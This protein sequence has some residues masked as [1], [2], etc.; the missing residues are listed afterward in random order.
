MVKRFRRS[1]A[2]DDEQLPSDISPPLVLQRTLNYLLEEIVAGPETLSKVHKFVWDRTRAIRND[3]SIQQVTEPDDVRVAMDCFERI[4][5]FHIL[6]LHQLSL[7][8]NVENSDFDAHQELEQLSKTLLSLTYYY[9]DNRGTVTSP[10][11]AEFRAYSIMIEIG[12]PR[13][14]LEQRANI[15]DKHVLE[16]QQVQM[17]LSLYAMCGGIGDGEGPWFRGTS[18]EVGRGNPRSF[19]PFLKSPKVPYLLAC[20]AEISFY[21]IRGLILESVWN[22]FKDGNANSRQMKDWFVEDVRAI[23]GFDDVDQA[24]GFCSSHGLSMKIVKGNKRVLD[25]E[26]SHFQR[27]TCARL[28]SQPRSLI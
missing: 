5:R 4:A 10:N 25:L 13:P 6:A 21:H 2:G 9:D 11:E 26:G 7:P 14:R 18:F 12:Y 19:F 28:E 23:L 22:E 15:W 16:D 27:G 8:E 20:V 3:F 24:T 17:A 1:A